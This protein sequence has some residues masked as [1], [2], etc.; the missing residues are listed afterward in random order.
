MSVEERPSRGRCAVA[1]RGMSAGT[2][3]ARFSGA[4]Y[5]C[6]PLPSERERWCVGCFAQAP[7]APATLL[8]CSKCKWA[9]YCSRACQTSD[10]KRHRRECPVLSAAKS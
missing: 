8:R 2:V 5:A 9:R 7:A 3:V 4:P 10:W 1:D 6:C